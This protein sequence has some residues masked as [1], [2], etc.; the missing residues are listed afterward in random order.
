MPA[1]GG[2]EVDAP[3]SFL[4]KTGQSGRI[5]FFPNVHDDARYLAFV[6]LIQRSDRLFHDF[7]GNISNH[8]FS[9][10]FQPI[11]RRGE[12]YSA[13]PAGDDGDRVFDVQA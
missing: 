9:T 12:A 3:V 13:G 7:F 1:K 8:D 4:G 2:D 11:L 6:S 5:F 10:L